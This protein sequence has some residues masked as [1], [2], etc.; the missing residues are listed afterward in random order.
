MSRLPT[1]EIFVGE[2]LP[3]LGLFLR[4]NGQL[5]TGLAAGH[6]FELKVAA[7]DGDVLITKTDGIA[8]Q[9]GAGF[10]PL[11]TPNLLIQWAATDELDKLVAGSFLAQLKVTRDSDSRVR[12]VQWL[13]RA[14]A[15]L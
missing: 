6:T 10:P 2:S 1:Y 15:A 3:T 11:G 12:I 8:G 13:I 9:V 7:L 14:R 5:V 4:E